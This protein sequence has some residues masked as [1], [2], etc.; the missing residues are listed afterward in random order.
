MVVSFFQ[1]CGASLFIFYVCLH[2]NTAVAACVPCL[3]QFPFVSD[4]ADSFGA[5]GRI[6]I[7]LGTVEVLMKSG[8]KWTLL[9]RYNLYVIHIINDTA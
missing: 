5:L 9:K 1:W 7:I 2:Q 3:V 6:E 4:E 8:K